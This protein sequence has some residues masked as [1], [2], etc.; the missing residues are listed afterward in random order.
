MTNAS[1]LDPDAMYHLASVEQWATYQANGQIE[2]ASLVEE[3]FIHCSWGRQVPATLERHFS[4]VTDLLAL[5]LDPAALGS[6]ELVVE[7]APGVGQAFPHAYG[8]IPTAAVVEVV[9]VA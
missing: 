9:A 1:D 2:P 4:G 8:P 6:T 5:R 3:G 7:Q